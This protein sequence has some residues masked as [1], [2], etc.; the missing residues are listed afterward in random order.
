MLG[1]DPLLLQ[2]GAS[3]GD[4]RERHELYARRLRE[5]FPGSELRVLTY[6]PPGQLEVKNENLRILG[7][8]SRHRATFVFDALRRLP[9][10][11]SEGWRPDVVTT[12]TPWEEGVVGALLARRLGARFVPQVHFEL[13]SPEW[14]REHW[15]NPWRAF[16]AK[17]TLRRAHRIR[18]VSSGIGEKIAR[19]CGIPP[20]R[21]AVVP[22]GVR[23]PA[24][25]PAARRRRSVLFVGHMYERKNMELWA[26]VA[27]RVAAARSDAV[28]VI[29]G[30]GPKEAA[31]RRELEASALTARCEFLGRRPHGEL[32]SIYA[33]AGVFLLTS[34]YE[35]FGRVVL[36]AMLSELPV[37]STRC[38]G[39]ED[40]LED[41]RTGYLVE[42]G[43]AQA[44]ADRVVHLLDDAGQAA[45]IGRA[46]REHARR[47]FSIEALADRLID[48]WAAA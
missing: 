41:G 27:R 35:G 7:S 42:R 20:A 28:F 38:W 29:V 2:P 25:P 4:A 30:D 17:R 40:L 34:H 32:P 37:V 23:F 12:Q 13:F 10:L 36:E 24:A 1:K 8:A 16:V 47:H 14:R 48:T 21:I 6:A 19:E 44:L 18:V 46:G 9:A 33:S 5:R 43:N 39:P 3:S 11:L 31:F 15:L 26:E 45:A 22:V